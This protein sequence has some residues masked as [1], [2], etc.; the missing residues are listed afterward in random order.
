MRSTNQADGP[1]STAARPRRAHPT[2]LPRPR[3]PVSGALR[4]L[5]TGPPTQDVGALVNSRMADLWSTPDDV[6]WWRAGDDAALALVYLTELH[7]RGLEG[8]DDRWE[9]SPLLATARWTLSGPIR[10]G[11][12]RLAEADDA[13]A[14]PTGC[15]VVRLVVA[16]VAHASTPSPSAVA[17][18]CREILELEVTLTAVQRLR[19]RDAHATLL[20]SLA[21]A[22][23][24]LL[25][26]TLAMAPSADVDDEREAVAAVLHGLGLSD[27][28]GSLLDTLPGAALWRVAVLDHL[29]THRS[30]RASA[31]GWLAAADA[32]AAAG[33]FVTGDALRRHGLGT[34]TARAWD[35][36][37]IG[38]M[39]TLEAAERLVDAEPQLA[40]DVLLGARACVTAATAV[41]GAVDGLRER[42][43]G[44]SPDRPS[45][46]SDNARHT[47]TEGLT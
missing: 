45:D 34:A 1:G 44:P 18:G 4:T 30:S 25:A 47:A 8:V 19:E 12:E 16:L 20:P 40:A 42:R 32:L 24:R 15:G 7:R 29:V 35:E 9:G 46:T 31:L 11:L 5:L 6:P 37:V 13:P 27:R 21:G 10:R 41:R 22:P 26:Q 28:T 23:R 14:H 2:P 3:G 39:A 17:G 36:G 33:R 38:R 43:V